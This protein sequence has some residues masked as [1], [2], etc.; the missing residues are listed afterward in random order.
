MVYRAATRATLDVAES[1]PGVLA[2]IA[3]YHLL[4][5]GPFTSCVAEAGGFIRTEPDLPAPDMQYHFA[6]LLFL[7]HGFTREK[8]CF[9]SLGPTLLT[10]ASR[11]EVRL[12]SADPTRPPRIDPRYLSEESDVRAL[13]RGYR[14]GRDIL[15]SDDFSRWLADAY[16]PPERLVGEKETADYIRAKADHVYHPVGTA[17]MGRDDDPDAVTDTEL[18]VRGIEGLRVADAS[19][20]PTIT[21]GNTN[22]PTMMIAEKA[23]ALISQR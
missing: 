17:R 5:R 2:N 10:P 3:R 7:D 12:A 23:A 9:C 18:R 6:P 20:M 4:G 14:I 22:A 21:R 13:V 19:V 15:E 8:G 11:G 16:L 1:F